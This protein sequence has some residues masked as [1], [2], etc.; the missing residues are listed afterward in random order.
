MLAQQLAPLGYNCEKWILQFR[1][2]ESDGIGRLAHKNTGGWVRRIGKL[3]NRQLD[4]GHCGGL[5]TGEARDTV[6][7]ATPASLATSAIVTLLALSFFIL[8]LFWVAFHLLYRL[9]QSYPTSGDTSSM[10]HVS[11]QRYF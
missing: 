4:L 7:G 6:I 9:F 8:P 5:D 10:A 1:D 3:L 11:L 2:D